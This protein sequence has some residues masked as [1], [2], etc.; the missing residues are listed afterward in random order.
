MTDLRKRMLNGVVSEPVKTTS[1][2]AGKTTSPVTKGVLVP[3]F[4]ARRSQQLQVDVRMH[5]VRQAR[6]LKGK[7]TGSKFSRLKTSITAAGRKVYNLF[8]E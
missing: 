8:F 4:M 6:L 3:D 1:T 2:A 5:E 7:H